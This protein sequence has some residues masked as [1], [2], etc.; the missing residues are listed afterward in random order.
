MMAEAIASAGFV[1]ER[2]AEPAPL[3]AL[4]DRDPAA[5]KVIRTKPRFLFFRLRPAPSAA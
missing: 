2:L 3:A 4:A 1:I 5:Y